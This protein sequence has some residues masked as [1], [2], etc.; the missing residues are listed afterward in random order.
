M[1]S[2]PSDPLGEDDSI[3]F[4]L[5]QIESIPQIEHDFLHFDALDRE[6]AQRYFVYLQRRI[7]DP[8]RYMDKGGAG[9]VF[10]INDT[11]CIKMVEDRWRLEEVRAR[12]EGRQLYKLDIG[13]RPVMEARIQE[14]VASLFVD[15]VRAPHLTQYIPGEFWHGIVMERLNAV[16][17]QRCLAGLDIFPENFD[18]NRYMDALGSYLEALHDEK[19][20]YHGDL[21]PRN[22]MIDKETGSPYVIDF[23]RSGR[24]T[25]EGRSLHADADWQKYDTLY[26]RLQKR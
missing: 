24:I 12:E 17:M 18:P 5:A 11:V 21:E 14:E 19:S 16:N 15:G 6:H 10:N 8:A 1:N 9:T 26:E 13:N 2:A 7:S 23:G 25:K 22:V 4:D 3:E 20:I